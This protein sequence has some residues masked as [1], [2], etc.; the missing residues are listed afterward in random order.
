MGINFLGESTLTV[1]IHRCP[2]NCIFHHAPNA[3]VYFEFDNFKNQ[4]K[5]YFSTI[6]KNIVFTIL[7][8]LR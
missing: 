7:L 1:A 5:I 8:N 2:K 3:T 4:D 6:S